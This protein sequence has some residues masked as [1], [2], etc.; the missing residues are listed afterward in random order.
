MNRPLRVAAYC[1][2]STDALDQAHSLESQ[3]RYFSELIEENPDWT[4][5]GVY[6]DEGLS[7]TCLK[8]RAAF[9]RMIEAAR[10]GGID[11]ILTREVSRFARNTSLP[12]SQS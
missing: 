5:A 9:N 12:P 2:V 8:K 3:V 6:A 4:M 7:G 11:L 1:R 10:S